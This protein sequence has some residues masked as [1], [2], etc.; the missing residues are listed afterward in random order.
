MLFCQQHPFV[1]QPTRAY[2]GFVDAS[3]TQRLSAP[4][5]RTIYSPGGNVNKKNVKKN[6]KTN[7]NIL[8]RAR[9]KT[10]TQLVFTIMEAIL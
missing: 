3:M 9:T 5:Q 1:R 10:G 4:Q 6:V 8:L 7:N 2:D